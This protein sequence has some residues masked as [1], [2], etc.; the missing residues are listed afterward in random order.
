MCGPAFPPRRSHHVLQ[1]ACQPR[2]NKDAIKTPP[3]HTNNKPKKHNNNFKGA[4]S[5]WPTVVAGPVEVYIAGRAPRPAVRRALRAL[6]GA[7][8]VLSAGALAGSLY[9]FGSEARHFK[10]LQA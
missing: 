6:S 5:F 9:S 4:I 1:A 8:F 10:I 3:P 2:L 7:V